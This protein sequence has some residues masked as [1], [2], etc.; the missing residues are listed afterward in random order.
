MKRCEGGFSAEPK[1]SDD[2]TKWFGAV[3]APDEMARELGFDA[4]RNAEVLWGRWV[5]CIFTRKM[6]DFKAVF[7]QKLPYD[8][9]TA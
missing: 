7:V 8:G 3:S 1:K 9:R 6:A 4:G 5:K 2:Q